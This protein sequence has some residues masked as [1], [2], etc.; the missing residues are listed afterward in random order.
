MTMQI[1]C[2]NLMSHLGW[3]CRYLP[4][5]DA[6]YVSS[7]MRLP[8]GSPF[9]FFLTEEGSHV[10]LTDDGLTLFNLRGLGYALNDKRSLRSIS[11]IAESLGLALD[12]TG[13]VT[14]LA[15]LGQMA[16]L[17]QKMQIFSARIHDWEREHYASGDADLSLAD[18]VERLMKGKAPDWLIMP[19]PVV[20]LATGDE[21]NFMF[22]WGER[23]VDAIPPA[24]QAT[25]ARMRKAIQVMRDAQS[26]LDTLYIVDDRAKPEQATH[27]VALLGQVAKAIR[28]SD[29]DRHYSPDNVL[30]A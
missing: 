21:V 26:D 11:G 6:L 28:L 17:G 1:N 19:A 12:D 23:Y 25:S 20:R 7:P 8:N 5:H 24:T 15:K 9:D 18:E 27:E 2:Q 29:F 3:H 30:V 13:A 4:E 14:G 22:K 16:E 10:R